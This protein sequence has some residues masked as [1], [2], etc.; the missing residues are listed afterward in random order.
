MSKDKECDK[1]VVVSPDLVVSCCMKKEKKTKRR[2][3]SDAH[4]SKCLEIIS[5]EWEVLSLAR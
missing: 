4:C 5:N 2:R 1:G 3:I